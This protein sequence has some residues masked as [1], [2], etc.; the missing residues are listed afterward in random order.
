MQALGTQANP[1]PATGSF[2]WNGTDAWIYPAGIVDG[3]TVPTR[4]RGF[5]FQDG[6]MGEFNNEAWASNISFNGPFE[7]ARLVA[8]AGAR[9]QAPPTWP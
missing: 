9:V 2:A 1:E 3:L 6:Q 5:L 4:I 8:P 7:A